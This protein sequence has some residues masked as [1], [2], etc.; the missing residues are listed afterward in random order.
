MLEQMIIPI[1]PGIALPEGGNALLAM[2]ADCL[3]PI[4][5]RIMIVAL[6]RGDECQV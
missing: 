2:E 3:A 1:K 5:M 4:I 6:R